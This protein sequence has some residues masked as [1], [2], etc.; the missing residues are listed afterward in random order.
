M[1]GDLGSAHFIDLHVDEST[2]GLPYTGRIKLIE[3]S[4]RKLHYLLAECKRYFLPL[5]P[6]NNIDGFLT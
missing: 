1:L 3:E 2:Y 6:P 4:E 5:T